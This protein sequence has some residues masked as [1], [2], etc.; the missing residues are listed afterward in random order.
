MYGLANPR[1]VVLRLGHRPVRDERVSTHLALVA[2]AFGASEIIFPEQEDVNV[3]RKVEDVVERFGG[4]FKVSFERSWHNIIREWTARGG[5]VV[6][7]TMYG[8][9]LP[10]V[11]DEIRSI[12]R[13]I[14]VVV[15]G[16]KV[17][18]EVYSMATYNVSVTNQPHSEIAALAVFLDHYFDGKE[19]YLEF[20]GAKLRVIPSPSGKNV[21]SIGKQSILT[22]ESGENIQ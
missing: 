6:H 12:N 11:I 10:E 22:A 20:E 17:P 21:V 8:V 18:R 2:R 14:M 7:L 9:P 3:R 19:F 15:G 13:D 1:V 16:A 4:S 5:V